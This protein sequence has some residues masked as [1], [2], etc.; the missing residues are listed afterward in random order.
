MLTAALW[1]A[2]NNTPQDRQAKT[3]WLGLFLAHTCSHPEH[4]G[5]V[6]ATSTWTRATPAAAPW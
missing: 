1:S 6:Y 4:V 3:A 5:E 2:C